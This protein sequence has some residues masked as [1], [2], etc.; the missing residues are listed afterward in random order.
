[1]ISILILVVLAWTFYIGYSRGLILQAF[2]SASS[3]LAMIVAAQFYR[4]LANTL[5]LW[6]PYSSAIEGATT[7]FFPSSQLFQLDQVFYAGL[8]YLII[9][10]IVY[11]IARFF[12]IFVHLVPRRIFDRLGGNIVAGILAAGVALF[13]IEMA[14]M[15][16]STIPMSQIQEPLNSS[17]LARFIINNTPITSNILKNLWVTNIIG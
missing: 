14:L 15:V 1:M 8:A 6:V 4:G 13:V 16:L 2:Y 17:G 9:Y 5:S 12:G 11:S 7:Y 3:I 10:N